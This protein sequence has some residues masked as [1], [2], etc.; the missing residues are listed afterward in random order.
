MIIFFL[1]PCKKGFTDSLEKELV[2]SFFF[3]IHSHKYD[4]GES[5]LLKKDSTVNHIFKLIYD[6][7]Y[8]KA[9]T[10]L[11]RV[12]HKLDSFYADILK[13]DLYWW[14]Y[15]K[16]KDKETTN[17]LNSMI[18]HFIDSDSSTTEGKIK[19]LI[20]KSYQIRYE[21][22]RYNFIGAAFI[23]S[24]IKN[25]IAEIKQENTQ[26]SRERAKLFDLY[27]LLF[28]YFD[29][30]L[31]PFFAENKRTIRTNSLLLLDEYTADQDLIVK[32]LACYFVGKIYLNI[33]KEPLKSKP[34]FEFLTEKFPKNPL[35]EELLTDCIKK[36]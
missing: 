2:E 21:F 6:Q 17:R 12:N 29:N 8:Q 35:F 33:E 19:Q 36:I 13:I 5:T 10:E 30:L 7:Q 11:T 24:D 23:R 4:K 9:E 27:N 3:L 14:E 34:C 20:G 32:T 18:E 15:V 25:L 22:G 28:S 1:Y 31:N 26:Y 16:S